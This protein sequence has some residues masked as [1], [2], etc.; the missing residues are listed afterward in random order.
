MFIL[1]RPWLT[2]DG[3]S[4]G[5]WKNLSFTANYRWTFRWIVDI[6][7]FL[8]TSEDRWCL[9]IIALPLCIYNPNYIRDVCKCDT[10]PCVLARNF[11]HQSFAESRVKYGIITEYRCITTRNGTHFTWIIA[12]QP[13]HT[14]WLFKNA[15][16]KHWIVS[17]PIVAH[18]SPQTC[19]TDICQIRY[20]ICGV[21]WAKKYIVDRVCFDN[22]DGFSIS[23]GSIWKATEPWISTN[24]KEVTDIGLWL[25]TVSWALS[26]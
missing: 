12:S 24:R 9:W 6:A 1:V 21:E 20:D 23:I 22:R 3:T 25:L 5:S 11:K 14:S 8:F 15:S 10:P 2:T 13:Y 26:C 17:L 16:S 18:S 7:I 19:G 4:F